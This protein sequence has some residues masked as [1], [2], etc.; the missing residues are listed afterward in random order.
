MEGQPQDSFP[1]PHDAQ[2][3]ASH[4][5]MYG[6][7]KCTKEATRDES[8]KKVRRPGIEPGS[9][10]WQADIIPLDQRRRSSCDE[11]HKGAV[12]SHSWKRLFF[13]F[14]CNTRKLNAFFSL[15]WDFRDES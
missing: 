2:I 1:S 13:A 10:A 8:K 14:F 7:K 6:R 5:E 3:E 15:L 9:P 4:F 12:T 11:K